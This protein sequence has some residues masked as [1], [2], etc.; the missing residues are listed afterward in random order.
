LHQRP[1]ATDKITL[2]AEAQLHV[3]I[4]YTSNH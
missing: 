4:T 2:A 1:T 3:L